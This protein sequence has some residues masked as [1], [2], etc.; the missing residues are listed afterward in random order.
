MR[1]QNCRTPLPAGAT[2]CTRCGKTL[3]QPKVVQQQPISVSKSGTMRCLNCGTELPE[4]TIICT[5]CGRLAQ[6]LEAVQQ[7]PEVVQQQSVSARMSLAERRA[8]LEQAIA[9][10]SSSGYRVVSQTD[11]TAQMVKPR[12]F[13][14]LW[15][16]L[17]LLFFGIGLIIYILYYLSKRDG[18]IYLSVDRNGQLTTQTS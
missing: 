15:S 13:S 6:Q 11:T 1:C 14:C 9:K 2:I 18:I 3:Q 4:A 17:W 7:Q 5:S 12:V 10:Y 16:L 8:I